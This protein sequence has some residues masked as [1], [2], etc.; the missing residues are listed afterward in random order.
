[1]LL[2]ISHSWVFEGKEYQ[3]GTIIEV[4]SEELANDL[5]AGSIACKV[6]KDEVDKKAK[7]PKLP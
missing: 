5:I 6:E 2:K 1:M 7:F 4:T 3:I